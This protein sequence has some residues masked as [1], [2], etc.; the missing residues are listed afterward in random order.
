[1]QIHHKFYAYSIAL[2]ELL[3]RYDMQLRSLKDRSY[4]SPD[5]P[6]VTKILYRIDDIVDDFYKKASNIPNAKEFGG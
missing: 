5:D 4:L 3:R 1:M 2:H 6:G